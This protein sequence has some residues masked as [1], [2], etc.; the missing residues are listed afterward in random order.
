[1]AVRE[2]KAAV[3]AISETGAPGEPIEYTMPDGNKVSIGAERWTIPEVLMVNQGTL[4][5]G[6]AGYYGIPQMVYDAVS[7]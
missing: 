1:M 5:N 4:D 2:L 6:V 7:R 3:F